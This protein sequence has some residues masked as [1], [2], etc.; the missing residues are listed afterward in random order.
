MD[1][2]LSKSKNLKQL[3]RQTI[4][5]L[6]MLFAFSTMLYAQNGISVKGTVTDEAAE[7]MIGATVIVKGQPSLGTVTDIDGNFQLVVPSEQSVLVISYVGMATKEVRVGKQRNIKVSLAEENQLDEVVVVGYGQQKKA[8]VVG[9]ITQTTGEVLE[10][11]A[12]IG[13]V[14][15]ALT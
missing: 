4:P 13:S 9:A 7:P 14:S 2:N 10:R 1:Q 8:S 15:A 12:G 5:T 11:A 3:I 6:L